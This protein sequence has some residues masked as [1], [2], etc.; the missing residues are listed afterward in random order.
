M[1]V[2]RMFFKK[3]FEIMKARKDVQRKKYLLGSS[4]YIPSKEELK[5]LEKIIEDFRQQNDL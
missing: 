2:R 3:F 1:E 5:E 4:Q